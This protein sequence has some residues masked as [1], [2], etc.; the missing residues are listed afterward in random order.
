ML[1]TYENFPATLHG[2]GHFL[3]QASI[4]RLQQRL[5]ETFQKLNNETF[6]IED[7]TDPSIPQCTVN[8][9]FGIAETDNFN[10]I[11]DEEAKRALKT[12][13]KKPFINMDFLCALRY[14]K[15]LERQRKPLRFDY[16][17]LRFAFNEGTIELQVFHEKG[18]RYISPEDIIKFITDKIN[19]GSTK[20]ILK[21]A[22]FL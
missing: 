12:I 21:D 13:L 18:P 7:V 10:Y 14:H 15:M 5:T 22:G 16:Y 3:V 1:G 8:F 9:E 11:D 4:K 20:R 17:M 6:A 2:T 19:Q